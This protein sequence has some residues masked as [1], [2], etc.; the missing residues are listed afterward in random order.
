MSPNFR[1]GAGGGRADPQS[2]GQE[3]D[4]VIDLGVYALEQ[5]VGLVGP[6]EIDGAPPLAGS[7][8]AQFLL[9]DQYFETDVG[10]RVDTL[11]SLARTTIERL[12][13]V[14]LP[15]PSISPR[16]WHPSSNNAA[17][18]PGPRRGRSRQC[19]RPS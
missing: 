7:N 8:T 4:G 16:R 6:L 12:L 10:E 18:S 15:R 11:E 13:S 3:I 9:V 2:G 5:P 19:S 17:F 14:A 1:D